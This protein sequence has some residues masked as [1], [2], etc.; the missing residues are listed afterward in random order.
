MRTLSTPIFHFS[1]WA[2]TFG[3]FSKEPCQ[4]CQ[5]GYYVSSG[6]T[7]EKKLKTSIFSNLDSDLQWD[8]LLTSSQMIRQLK[9]LHSRFPQNILRKFK[10]LKNN[11]NTFFWSWQKTTLTSTKNFPVGSPFFFTCPE[12]F[13]RE[14]YWF[15]NCLIS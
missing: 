7:W 9:T 2:K 8:K 11:I 15:N 13:F 12:S 4:G 14:N 5:N 1:V 6:S 3:L 10:F